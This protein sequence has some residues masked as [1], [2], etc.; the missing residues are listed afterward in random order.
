MCEKDGLPTREKKKVYLLNYCF[1]EFVH[2]LVSIQPR[3]FE[4][5]FSLSSGINT[6]N[7]LTDLHLPERQATAFLP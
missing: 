7:P 4:L 3:N 5:V 6:R 1:V 2:S